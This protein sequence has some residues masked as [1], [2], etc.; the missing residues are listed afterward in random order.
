MARM[1]GVR[2]PRRSGGSE[3]IDPPTRRQRT[4]LAKLPE[5]HRVVGVQDGSAIVERPDGRLSRVKPNGRVVPRAPVPAAQ[6][7]LD[8][9]R[10]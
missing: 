1:S 8:M 9:Q 3:R 5:D 6:S 7:Y 4:S 10:C 2:H